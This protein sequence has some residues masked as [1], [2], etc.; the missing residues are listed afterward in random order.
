MPERVDAALTDNERA[1]LACG[2]REWGGPAAPTTQI[3]NLLGFPEIQAL[4]DDGR[5]IARGIRSGEP[6]APTDW[7]RALLATEIVFAS[8]LI[9]SG[10]E[11]ATTTGFSDD[12]SIRLLRSIQRKLASIV[13]AA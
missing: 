8:D 11:W 2:L 12:E 9:G 5:S 10:V 7:R 13:R 6:L 4:Y 3:A 1:L